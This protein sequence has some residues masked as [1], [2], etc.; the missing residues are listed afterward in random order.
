MKP[1]KVLQIVGETP[2][3]THDQ[4]KALYDFILEHR[5]ARCLELGFAHG[6][7]TVWIAAALQELGTGKVISVD[8]MT[9]LNRKP[10]AQELVERAGL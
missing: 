5:L 4:G 2:H 8:N 3:T 6:V 1:T 7:R 10:S 9:V